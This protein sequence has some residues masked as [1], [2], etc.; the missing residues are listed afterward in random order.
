VIHEL[1]TGRHPYDGEEAPRALDRNMRVKP[2]A[3]LSETQNAALIQALSLKRDERTASLDELSDALLHGAVSMRSKLARHA[4]PAA[5]AVVTAVILGGAGWYWIDRSAEPD[6]RA[7]ETRR[8]GED[9][10]PARGGLPPVAEPEGNAPPV[11]EAPPADAPLNAGSPGD[12]CARLEADWNATSCADRRRCYT[13]FAADAQVSASIAPPDLTPIYE[14][15]ERMFRRLSS[16]ACSAMS[17]VR[18]TE[19]GEFRRQFPGSPL[20]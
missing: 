15:R 10:S 3:S 11:A 12:V 20:H 8:A 14:A 16:A 18:D 5:I 9:I 2:I 1:L 7:A 13:Q 6:G 17:T 19:Y 4:L